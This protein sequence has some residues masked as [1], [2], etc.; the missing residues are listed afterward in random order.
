MNPLPSSKIPYGSFCLADNPAIA[1]DLC[2]TVAEQT[3]AF[4]TLTEFVRLQNN[5]PEKPVKPEAT[6]ARF[7]PKPDEIPPALTAKYGPKKAAQR[8]ALANLKPAL[9]AYEI[10]LKEYQELSVQVRAIRA[11]ADFSNRGYMVAFCDALAADFPAFVQSFFFT[12]NSLLVDE[13]AR[14]KHT[15]ICAGTG[16][17][18]SETA[19]TLIR[20]YVTKNTDTAVVVLDPHGTLAEQVARFEELEAGD[21]LVYVRPRFYKGRNVSFNPFEFS[22]KDEDSL[23]LAVQHF[24]GALK[25]IIGKDFT[26]TQES[27]LQPIL[28]VLFH[29]DG[30]DFRDLVRFMDDKRNADLVA[31]GRNKIPNEIDQSFFVHEFGLENFDSSKKALRYRF[32]NAIRS[33]LVREFFCN[34]TTINLPELIEQGKVIVFQFDKKTQGKKSVQL[35]GQFINAFLVSYSFQRPE[36]S[37]VIHL[38][39]DECQYFVS[40]TIEEIMGESRKF[41]L[42]ATLITQ[43]IDQLSRDLQKAMIRNVGTYIIGRS[44]GE[45]A[46][47]MVEEHPKL[48]K[49]DI[50]DLPDLTFF[51]IQLDRPPVKTKIQYIGNKHG[52][53]G[54]PWRDVLM[55]QGATYYAS[56]TPTPHE[57]QQTPSQPTTSALSQHNAGRKPMFKAPYLGG[58]PKQPKD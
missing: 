53:S 50:Q 20:H 32:N 55:K 6:D 7:Q 10:A 24:M 39:A 19:K 28:T 1:A 4:W 23:D 26:D 44:G 8:V 41:G 38:F 34:P 9:D 25:E 27:L 16:A 58:P 2:N 37:K 21:R 51:Q 43:G 42:H 13:R 30:T 17:G 45:T 57:H 46:K 31:H 22:A 18:K 29:K 33:P 12:P 11:A 5:S 15:F 40:P 56:E 48:T 47:K 49:E 52:L 35:I 3:G 54:E 36:G 14:E